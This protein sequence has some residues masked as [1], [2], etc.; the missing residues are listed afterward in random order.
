MEAVFPSFPMGAALE[1]G[2]QIPLSRYEK[3]DI[4]ETV[5]ICRRQSP[6]GLAPRRFY[7]L[8]IYREQVNF[9]AHEYRIEEKVYYE[10]CETPFRTEFWE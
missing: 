4:L 3:T 9:P 8:C 7:G 10:K 6:K 2:R 1:N 5:E